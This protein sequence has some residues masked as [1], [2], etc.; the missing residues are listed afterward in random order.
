MDQL[1]ECGVITQSLVTQYG[2]SKYRM[3]H[4]EQFVGRPSLQDLIDRSSLV[5]THGGA[6]VIQLLLSNKPFVAFPNPR[7]AG[8]HQTAFLKQVSSVIDISWSRRVG[9]LESLYLR[10]IS[11]GASVITSQLPKAADLIHEFARNKFQ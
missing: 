8:D 3:R 2:Q 1:A 9:D 5:I 4:G 6:T 11:L 7:G 10:R